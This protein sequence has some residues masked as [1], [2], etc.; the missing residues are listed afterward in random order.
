MVP[1]NKDKNKEREKGTREIGEIRKEKQ[2]KGGPC[3]Q[4][5]GFPLVLFE[6]L[7]ML[8]TWP[9]LSSIPKGV[10]HKKQVQKHQNR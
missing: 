6:H 3:D 1:T 10:V 2:Q 5:R 4:A 7:Q 9:C 8:R